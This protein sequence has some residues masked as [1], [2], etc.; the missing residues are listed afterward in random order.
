MILNE[1]SKI[2]KFKRGKFRADHIYEFIQAQ[3]VQINSM[4]YQEKTRNV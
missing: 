2:E 1:K 3:E 4:V